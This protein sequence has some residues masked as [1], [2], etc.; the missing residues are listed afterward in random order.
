MRRGDFGQ[1][2]KGVP[3]NECFPAMPAY[4]RRVQEVKDDLASRGVHVEHV[5]V[6][7]SQCIITRDLRRL[8]D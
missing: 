2:C 6:Q 8:I 5:V 7:S 3:E 4:V 1:W